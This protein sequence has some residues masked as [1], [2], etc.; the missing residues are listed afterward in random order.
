MSRLN[1]KTD[2]NSSNALESQ[3]VKKFLWLRKN[4][5]YCLAIITLTWI[6][7]LCYYV[8]NFIGWSSIGALNPLDFA[9]FILL[10]T[11]PL[12][13][14]WFVL[15]YIERSSSLD[16]NALLF[17]DY[18]DNLMYP[19]DKAS[20]TASAIS[21]ALLEQMVKLQAEN[22]NIVEQS[23]LLKNDLD[24]RISEFGK[25]LQ[26]LDTYS[27]NTLTQLN[28]EI[29]N[30]SDK[31]AYI[32]DKTV[33]TVN[34]MQD[35]SEIIT[36]NSDRFLSKINPIV[37]EI[38]ALSANIKN[39]IAD[40]RSNLAD[41]KIQIAECSDIS[42]DYIE[43]ILAKTNDNIS[44]IERTFYKASEEYDVL[45]KK[46]DNSMSGIE[47]RIDDQKQLIYNQSQLINKNSELFNDKINGY[48]KL[49][50]E[51]IEKLVKNS[52]DIEKIAKQQIATLKAI[53][54]E[55]NKSVLNIGGV[56]D[57]KRAEI[58]RKCEYAIT[59]MQ[60]VIVAINKETEKLTSFTALTQAKNFDLQNVAETI[61]DKIGDISSKLALKTDSL[62]DKAVEVIDKFTEASEIIARSTDK[63]NTSS[64]LVI[65]S[66]KQGVKLLEE[67][68]FYINNT[69]SNIDRIREKLE[70]LRGEV[71]AVS[72]DVSVNLSG[73]EKQINKYETFKESNSI[74]NPIEPTLDFKELESIAQNINKIL[75]SFGVSVDEVYAKKD[76]FDL[77]DEYIK[78]SQ[79]VFIDA[80]SNTLSAKNIKTIRK[81]FDDNTIFH[82]LV[83]KYLFLMDL[84]LKETL[85]SNGSTKDEIINLSVNSAL[86]KVYFVLVKALNSVD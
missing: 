38:S 23:T 20:K 32:N 2:R 39:N 66:G 1:S 27:A 10:S 73:F 8:D 28:D 4:F 24:L 74:I 60:N 71:K 9:Y 63:I 6:V 83:I 47:G 55:T 22:K 50:S 70:G 59:S 21:K 31:C 41:M 19:D 72:D 75:K 65:D 45:Y 43:N 35:C 17:H 56:F 79:T 52:I 15:A 58:E 77:W 29:K 48:G 11:L 67:Q 5:A 86:D 3:F 49:I 14:F 13:A 57:E 64:N 37:D 85:S 7:G 16:A 44:R 69:V 46:L 54:N 26:I 62:K 18:I 82:N 51:E 25:I 12:L 84:A 40:N 68:S 76:M 80:I 61:V 30:L 81:S 42:K 78:G 34:R 33:K 53:S 36:Q